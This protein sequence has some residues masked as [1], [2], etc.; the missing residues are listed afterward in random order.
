MPSDLGRII[1]LV[2]VPHFLSKSLAA[3]A[4]G[5]GLDKDEFTR[6]RLALEQ[7]KFVA[8]LMVEK[9]EEDAGKAFDARLPQFEAKAREV[10]VVERQ[11]FL[12]PEQVSTSHILFDLKKHSKDEALAWV[13]AEFPGI[14]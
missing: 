3:Q 1:P 11:R 14:A 7:D 2:S 13:K 4:R 5:A 10:Y 9:I 8:G 12:A 6:R